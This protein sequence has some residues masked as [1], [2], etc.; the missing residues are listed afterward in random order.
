MTPHGLGWLV[1]T[2]AVDPDV[3]KRIF[4]GPAR[5]AA[6]SLSEAGTPE[7]G[8]QFAKDL[9]PAANFQRLQFFAGRFWQRWWHSSQVTRFW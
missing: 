9:A 8:L 7:Q 5:R 2:F 6:L 4:I 1:D 3:C